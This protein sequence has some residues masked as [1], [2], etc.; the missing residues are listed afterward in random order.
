[1]DLK[2]WRLAEAEDQY[3]AAMKK[4][5]KGRIPKGQKFKPG[6]RVRIADDLGDYM[7]HFKS[8]VNATVQYSYAQAYGGDNVESYSLDIDGFGECAWYKEHQLT[9]I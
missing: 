3:R 9:A 2:D 7:K 5:S 8:G 1:M 4:V 6:T